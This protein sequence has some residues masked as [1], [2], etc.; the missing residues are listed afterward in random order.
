M[1]QKTILLLLYIRLKN[2]V[3]DYYCGRWDPSAST[4]HGARQRF[5]VATTS[6]GRVHRM[7]HGG[8]EEVSRSDNLDRVNP[9]CNARVQGAFGS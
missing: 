5:R 9:A 1:E 2:Q 3:T 7:M 4:M 6:I 8:P